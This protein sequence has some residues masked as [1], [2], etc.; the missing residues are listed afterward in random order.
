MRL[1][2]E[3]QAGVAAEVR[4]HPPAA[5][6]KA[7]AELSERYRQGGCTRAAFEGSAGRAAYLASRLPATFAAVRQA[8]T[9]AHEL[10]PA[11]AIRSLLDLGAGPGTAAWVAVEMFPQ[12]ERIGFVERDA[13][14]AALGE[15]LA[16]NS[17]HAALRG[18]HWQVADLGAPLPAG[19]YDLVVISY[20]LGEL[21]AALARDVLQ[22]AWQSTETWLAVIE[23]GT[24]PGFEVVANA[25]RQLLAL[26]GHLL[27]PCP[28]DGECP[29][30]R[31]GDWCHFAAR[32][33]RSAEHRR[34]K[35][36]SMGY[37]DEKFSYVIA[38]REAAEPA[39]ARVVRHPMHHS[40]FVQLTL[41]AP[42][43]LERVT[44]TRSQKEFYR[45]AKK[46]EWGDT[47]D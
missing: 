19:Q 5:L 11:A 12:I 15:R 32:L 21:S 38:S 36:A 43:G 24:R 22:R 14:M 6:A 34:L 41:C 4:A 46:A 42:S 40:G 13:G 9:K 28:H 17:P 26:G 1:P 37:E 29:M 44:I 39:A 18:A 10:A 3:L 20:S 33:E 25:R 30:Q 7:A 8:L 27:A 35:Q 23:P 47:W 2:P 45:A 16:G 31:A